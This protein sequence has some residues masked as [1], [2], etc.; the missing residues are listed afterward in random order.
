MLLWIMIHLII[1]Q[2]LLY[3]FSVSLIEE[4]GVG[5]YR[6]SSTRKNLPS[7]LPPPPQVMLI[8]IL[9]DIQYLQNVAFNFVKGLNGQN[10]CSSNS[11]YLI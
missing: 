4:V 9:I 5:Q 7:V 2:D 11:H 1:T 10:P 8:L 6:L 3:G